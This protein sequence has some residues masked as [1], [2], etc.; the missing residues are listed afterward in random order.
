MDNSS[1]RDLY[2]SN[3][4]DQRGTTEHSGQSFINLW[5]RIH[6]FEITYG[7]SIEDGY[8]KTDYAKLL[9]SLNTSS[10]TCF[11]PYK[12]IVRKYVESLAN[13]GLIPSSSVNEIASVTYDD[14]DSSRL[15][16][17]KFFKDFAS[18]R[19]TIEF[20]LDESGKID[21]RIFWT[22][23]AAIYMAWCGLQIEEALA[24]KKSDV[25][26]DCIHVANRV[27]YPNPTI[28]D[29]MKAYRDET[30]Y[31]SAAKAIITLKYVPSEWLFRSAR[32]EHVDVPKTMRIFICN[33]GKSSGESNMFNYDKVYWSGVYHRAYL[34]EVENGLIKQ[35]D[36]ATISR[37]FNEN[38][39]SVYAANNRLQS[40]RKFAQYFYPSRK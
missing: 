24:L 20:T 29:F 28:M 21:A 2:I 35:G 9:T 7:K 39:Q 14:I 34:Y 10:I 37:A 13:D 26:D 19:E 32:S 8:M 30:E 17:L 1:Y 4:L 18:L 27:I 33:F 25:K 23:I 11:R 40:Y 31:Q 16:E 6:E 36:M 3:I 22:Q 5:R 15:Y 38:F 12:S